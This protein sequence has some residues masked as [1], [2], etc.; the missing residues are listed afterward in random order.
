MCV[1][2]IIMLKIFIE[3]WFWELKMLIGSLVELHT[4]LHSYLCF[5]LLEK[6]FLSY[7]DT[8]SIPPWYLA[9]S[10][11]SSAFS[12][13]NPYSFSTP[14]GSIEF[15][16][17]YLMICSLTPPRYLYLSKT[18]FLDTFLDR[19]LDTFL[20]R[21]L[22]TSRHLHLS[23]FTDALFNLALCDLNLILFNLSLNTSLFSLP[24]YLISLQS[25]FLKV[26]SSFFKIFFTW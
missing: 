7:L 3:R 5:S 8:S 26:S 14:G 9:V 24:N 25:L 18:I 11:A 20:D 1:F 6:Q 16:F 23:R 10:W 19:C 21:C 4:W 13:R 22:D 12:Y 15:L 2:G 17:L